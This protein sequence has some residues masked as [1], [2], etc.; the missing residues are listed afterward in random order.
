MPRVLLDTNIVIYR[1]GD[2]VIS[3]G[4]RELLSVLQKAQAEILIHPLSLDDLRR[5]RDERRRAVILSKAGTYPTL[6]APP[7][8]STDV[9]FFTSIGVQEG[10]THA[11]AVDEAILYA[12]YRDAVDFLITEDR[13]IHRRARRLGIHDRV[14]A[15]DDAIRVFGRYLVKDPTISPP[16]LKE[17]YVYNMSVDDAIFDSLK[18]EYP[19]FRDWYRDISRE[20]R[21]C[22]VHRRPEGGMGAV[23]IYKM[24]DEAIDDS[25]P[26]ISKGKRLKL[27][28]FKVA[29]EGHKIGELFL[30]L[31]VDIAIKNDIPEVYLTHFTQPSDRLVELISEYGFEKVAVKSSG[32]DLYLKRL[33]VNPESQPDLSPME[34]AKLYYPSFYDG[35]KVKKFVVPIRPKYHSRLFTDFPERQLTMS[36]SAGEFITEGNT[37]KKAYVCH[38]R[39]RQVNPGDLVLFYLSGRKMLTSIGVVESIYSALQAPDEILR[40][41]GRR[42]VYSLGEIVSMAVKPVT[43]I[44][45][46]HHF[47]MKHHVGLAELLEIGALSGAPQSI[48]RIDSQ[49]YSVIK[50]LGGIDERFTVH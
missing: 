2:R 48:S 5:D 47:H 26:P 27:S 43:V 30:K 10:A 11:V 29:H 42:T 20:G 32:E 34:I 3:P 18:Q 31:S 35:D 50:S 4:I 46:T 40:R 7:D 38:S 21:K 14:L 1:E 49:S 6:D 15:A 41:V 12:V 25:V 28:T 39:T 9:R 22:F 37:I 24:E 36:E 33:M 23:L 13:G 17:D 16:A 19:D 44:L 8:P 45:F